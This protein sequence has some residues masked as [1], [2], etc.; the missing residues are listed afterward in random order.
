MHA[1]WFKW[2]D[3]MN[4]SNRLMIHAHDRLHAR[5]DINAYECCIMWLMSYYAIDRI[6]VCYCRCLLLVFT[7]FNDLEICNITWHDWMTCKRLKLKLLTARKARRGM[8][9]ARRE[10]RDRNID[11]VELGESAARLTKVLKTK[12]FCVVKR[13]AVHARR[14]AIYWQIVRFY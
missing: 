11:I 7:C 5:D 14:G 8:S 2:Y 3:W 13:G 6:H 4:D 1:W 9:R 10:I 12:S